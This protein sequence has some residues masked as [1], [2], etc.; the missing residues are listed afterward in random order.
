MYKDKKNII[1]KLLAELNLPTCYN[2]YYMDLKILLCS[3]ALCAFTTTR[4]NTQDSLKSGID[5]SNMDLNVKPGKSFFNYV[6]GT[7]L[8]N[9]PIPA[10]YPSYGVTS[11]MYEENQKRLKDIILEQASQNNATNSMG[12]KI[13]DIYNIVMDSTKLNMDGI[14]PVK[15]LF[16]EISAIKSRKQVLPLM[17]KFYRKGIPGLFYVTISADSKDSKNNL[18]C[19]GQ[20]GMTLGE[21]GYYLD[22]DSQ[23]VALRDEYKKTIIDLFQLYGFNHAKAYANM[24]IVMDIETAMAKVA[25]SRTE[26]RDPE[27]NYHKKTYAELLKQY[28]GIDWNTYFPTLGMNGVKA[29]SVDQT[30]PISEAEKILNNMSLDDLKAYM[31]WKV[32]SSSCFYLSDEIRARAFA[33]FRRSLTG[34]QEDRARWKRAVNAVESFMGEGLGKLYVEKYFPVAYKERMIQLVKNL[35]IALGERIK[36]QDWMSDSTKVVALDKLAAFYV[37]IGYPNKWRDYSCLD[38]HND[39]YFANVMRSDAFDFDYMVTKKFNK[40]V[41]RDEWQMTPQEINAYYNPTTN[42]ICF[43][44]GILQPPFFDMEADDAYNYGSIGAVIGHEMTH[45]FDDEGSQFDKDGNLRIWWKDSDRKNFSERTKVMADFFSCINVLP[46]LKCNGELTLGENLADHGGLMI[47][48]QA[49]KN[50]TKNSPLKTKDGFTADQRFFLAYAVS[51]TE[52]S[53]DEYIRMLTK[54]DPHAIAIWRVDGQ[55]PHID[56]WYEAFG[57]TPNDP[58]YLPKEKRVTI[59]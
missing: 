52:K 1:K 4:A 17:A 22:T 23:S 8:K 49:Y 51:W 18:V 43:P 57:I 29:L 59:W 3:L 19:I 41:D 6:N 44:A 50:A 10:E 31:Q 30:A 11:V 42:E 27:S 46:D 36:A 20:D 25:Y 34:Q 38:I 13:G 45:G 32:I 12:Q 21:K 55:L 16:D 24:K 15:G 54:T 39:S 35:Q 40:A 2:F 37:K 7:W 28:P 33:F 48:Y 26:L 5:K 47:S 58:M 9:H 53:S 14:A 56:A